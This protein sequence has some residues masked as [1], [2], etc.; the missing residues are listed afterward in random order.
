[1]LSIILVVC[2]IGALLLDT[3]A[4][5]AFAAGTYTTGQYIISEKLG[6]NIRTVPGTGYKKIGA[7]SYNT[8]WQSD[9]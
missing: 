4:I 2:L 8:L 7:V 6:L 3:A 1:M 9:P 5:S